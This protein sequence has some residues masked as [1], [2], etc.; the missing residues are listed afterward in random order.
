MLNQDWIKVVLLEACTLK[1]FTWLDN[2]VKLR[3]VELVRHGLICLLI[4]ST[5][6]EQYANHCKL[7]TKQPGCL[8]LGE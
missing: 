8:S 3:D 1:W 5:K 4:M 2:K 6:H 7:H